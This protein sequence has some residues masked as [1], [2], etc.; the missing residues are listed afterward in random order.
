MQVSFASSSIVLDDRERFPYFFRTVPSDSL[1]A[2]GM[3]ELIEYFNWTRALLITQDTA[4]FRLVYKIQT[5]G[6]YLFIYMT[7][8]CY[9]AFRGAG[10][11]FGREECGCCRQRITA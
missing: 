3:A 2:V 10:G 9:V 8:V 11:K 5:S 6:F 4:A 7:H 1:V